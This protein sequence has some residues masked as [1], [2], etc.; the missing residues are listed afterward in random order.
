[1]GGEEDRGSCSDEGLIDFLTRVMCIA[2]GILYGLFFVYS[3]NPVTSIA[4][5]IHAS[6]PNESY[7]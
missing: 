1:M 5:S 3:F 2:F 7:I 4:A 6:S